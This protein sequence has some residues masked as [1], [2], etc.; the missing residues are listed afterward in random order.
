MRTI[1]ISAM[2]AGLL[3]L[4][5][6]G[7]GGES[8]NGG[9]EAAAVEGSGNAAGSESAGVQLQPG[10]WEMTQQ[11]V[12][13]SVPGMPAGAADMMKTGP[14]TVKTCI[15]EEQAQKPSADIFSGK[16]DPNCKQEG[17]SAE[18]GKVSGT[19]TCSGGDTGTTVMKM[20]GKFGPTEYDIAMEMKTQ[21]QGADMTMEVRSSGRR[22]GECPA[23]VKA[24]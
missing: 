13:V 20:D 15:T 10:Q 7:G 18:G 3:A 21:A 9:N 11:T 1:R 19:V 4:A 6:C 12:N 14:I 16:T 5:A 8:R 24:G 17:F 2:T 22:I 23:G